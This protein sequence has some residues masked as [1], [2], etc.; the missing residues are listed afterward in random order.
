MRAAW[1]VLAVLF[2]ALAPRKAA[3]GVEVEPIEGGKRYNVTFRIAPGP[4]VRRIH[5]AGSFNGW[6]ARALFA[7]STASVRY[8][9]ALRAGGWWSRTRSR[10]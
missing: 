8:R 5:L 2:L 10:P 6:D 1:L 9:F 3:A 4:P 7:P